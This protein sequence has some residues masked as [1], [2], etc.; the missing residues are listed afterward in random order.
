MKGRECAWNCAPMPV[1][2]QSDATVAMLHLWVDRLWL[3]SMFREQLFHTHRLCNLEVKR[4]C[5]ISNTRAP[6]KPCAS[7]P[8]VI[9]SHRRRVDVGAKLR[10]ASHQQSARV[11]MA[12]LPGAAFFCRPALWLSEKRRNRPALMARETRRSRVRSPSLANTAL[13]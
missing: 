10:H 13:M 11:L 4:A 3:H 8:R 12:G 1:L 2:V 7:L 9:V 5:R 6:E